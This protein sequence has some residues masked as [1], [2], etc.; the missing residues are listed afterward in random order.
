MAICIEGSKTDKHRDGSWVMIAKTNTKLCPVENVRKLIHWC[1]L[2]DEDYVLCN[3]CF[4][5]QG[6]IVRKTSRKMS[7]TNHR[8][9]FLE[10]LKPR[11]KVVSRYC[12]HSLRSGGA[13][14]AANNGFKDRLFKRHR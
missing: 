5:H 7:H 1:K 12:F 14:L 11:V 10:A 13:T 3:I 4:T 8:E 2:S 6:K 9:L